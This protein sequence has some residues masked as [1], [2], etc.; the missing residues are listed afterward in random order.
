MAKKKRRRPGRPKGSKNRLTGTAETIGT[1]L[2][3]VA[4]K[5]DGW[6]AQRKE[7]A[8]ELNAVITRARGMLSSLE[9]PF[10]GRKPGRRA[11]TELTTGEGQ[12]V[13]KGRTRKRRKMSKEAREKIAAAQR[14]RWAKQKARAK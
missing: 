1:A 11:A 9:V 10:P 6:M 13:G 2:G 5:L 12:G 14:A 8:N 3:N 4:A 7:I